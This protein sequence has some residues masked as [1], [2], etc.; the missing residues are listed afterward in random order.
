MTEDYK[1][2]L[3]DFITGNI[4]HG[5]P[6]NRPIMER[7]DDI[8]NNYS[9]YIDENV[10]GFQVFGQLTFT[11]SDN[12]V[13]Y[14][15]CNGTEGAI[16]ILNANLEPIDSFKAFSTGTLFKEFVVLKV[17]ENNE[18]YGVDY[19]SS[20]SRYRFIMLNNIA[21]SNIDDG[22]YKVKLIKSYLFPTEYNNMYFGTVISREIMM[23]KKAS[24][25]SYIFIGRNDGNNNYF[26]IIRLDV[27][28]GSENTWTTYTY[29]SL[30]STFFIRGSY[31][32]WLDDNSS[33]VI[34]VKIGIFSNNNYIEL[35]FN[36][37]SI[38]QRIT[39]ASDY[40]AYV[41]FLD[42]SSTYVGVSTKTET[43]ATATINKIDY[44]NEEYELIDSISFDPVYLRPS[45][46]FKNSNGIIFLEILGYNADYNYD[47]YIGVIIGDRLTKTSIGTISYQG[48]LLG[49]VWFVLNN[50]NLYK[51]VILNENTAIVIAIDYNFANYNGLPYDSTVSLIPN[52]CRLY[53]EDGNIIFARN[54]Y[55][56]TV[57][58][59]STTSIIQIPNTM[60]NNITISNEKLLSL[61]NSISVDSN[62]EITKNIYESLFI[63][64]INT[65]NVIDNENNIKSNSS[66]YINNN[67]SN[68]A[69]YN[70]SYIS[71][72]RI[73]YNDFT[74]EIIPITW[75][76]IDDTHKYI[77]FNLNVTKKIENIEIIS[78]DESTT[79]ITINANLEVGKYYKIKQYL[80][81]E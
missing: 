48:S 7:Q 14:G 35:Y 60:L 76:S 57:F 47:G 37:S 65:I 40:I 44:V 2:L 73:T 10:P 28:V 6:S 61:S 67:V 26:T 39:F 75:V 3:T 5:S 46:K 32:Y 13:L 53:D 12:I 15:N 69:N 52:K 59:N 29:S 80:K 55:N 11:N 66:R 8:L 23:Y 63:N 21:V 41:D 18:I 9:D 25:S 31:C 81:V 22:N 16:V 54:L 1:R 38:I 71:K 79:Y 50:F 36:G 42:S 4:T 62:L 78:N 72:I 77:Q 58:D 20:T 27:N 30:T 68:T 33:E 45:I 19:D 56:K 43:A 70:N 51:I 49:D 64:F 34:N 24:A 17:D 74:T